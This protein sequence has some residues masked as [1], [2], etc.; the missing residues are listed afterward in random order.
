[1]KEEKLQIAIGDIIRYVPTNSLWKVLET[2]D[3]TGGNKYKARHLKTKQIE[4]LD[5]SDVVLEMKKIYG[6]EI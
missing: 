6:E 3:M 1:M 4:L 5:H 2:T